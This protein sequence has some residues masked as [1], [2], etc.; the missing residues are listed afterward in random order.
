MRP[1]QLKICGFGPYAGE[2][3]LDLEK[4]G[5]SGLYLIT[6]DT[7]AGKTT[8]FDAICYALFGEASGSSREPG[9]LRSKYAD[10][11]TQTEVELTFENGG[12]QY[13]VKRNPEYL[14][15]KKRG[16]GYTSQP[17]GAEL[18]YPDGRLETKTAAVT[19]AVEE[20][21][22]I[23]RDQ[24]CQ[25]AMIAQGDFLKLLLADTKSRQEIF[26]D[27][28]RTNL[29]QLFQDRVKQ[30]LSE[31]EKTR[32]N[33]KLGVSLAVSGILCREEDPL[34]AK[35]Q[36]A[37]AGEL[38]TEDILTLID[39]LCE[40]DDKTLQRLQSAESEASKKLLTLTETLTKAAQ[41]RKLEEE[42]TSAEEAIRIHQQKESGLNEKL[43]AAEDAAK[44]A[45]A[46]EQKALVL[47]SRLSDYDKL[48]AAA[49]QLES[50]NKTLA[51]MRE[52]LRDKL[53][54]NAQLEETCRALQE[55]LQALAF[56]GENRAVLSAKAQNLTKEIAA[57]DDFSA[58]L[59]AL[60]PL[61]KA[62][63]DAQAAYLAA[64]NAS[65]DAAALAQEYRDR[66][67]REQAGIMA[68][69]LADGKPCPVCGST[70]HPK[71]A[72]KAADAPS[73]AQVKKAE[74]A[75][76]QARKAASDAASKSADAL[77]KRDAAEDAAAKKALQLL[78]GCGLSEAE[79]SLPARIADKQAEWKKTEQD[80][81]R[82]EQRV[83]RRAELEKE[84]PQKE[85][86]RRK[87]AEAIENLKVEG[88]GKK[89]NAEAL[90]TQVEEWKKDLEFSSRSEAE[91]TVAVLQQKAKS[92]RDDLQAAS[93][94]KTE[95]EKDLASLK[96]ARENCEK[97]L[98][99]QAPIDEAAVLEEQRTV[100]TARDQ[101]AERI[102]QTDHCLRANR[103]IEANIR[104]QE[105]LLKDLDARWQWMDALRRTVTGQLQGKERIELETWI[106]MTYFDRILRRA[107]V[108]L[109]EMSSGAYELKRR[110]NA[111][112]LRSQSGLELDVADHYNGSTRSVKTLSGGESFMAS[113][114]LALGLSEE[115]QA[116]AGGVRLDCMFVDE[117]FG[118]LDEDTLQQAMKALG[119]LTEGDRLVGII[120]HVAE[121]RRQI[122]RQIVVTKDPAG[123][124]RAELRL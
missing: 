46:W 33:A 72:V 92:V 96:A 67:N 57:L 85:E 63:T 73:E 97:L 75:A 54:E 119:R 35:V 79:A 40:T 62:V 25:I 23:D 47:A 12:K 38:L 59:K 52:D 30:D 104:S 37:K 22:G 15:K 27:L 117:G 36:Q 51:Q 44:S 81:S 124:S 11:D 86:Q 80:L 70:S 98:S 58:D 21:L 19:R 113:L 41:Q 76:E 99:Q 101:Y 53:Q 107:N 111:D 83:Q 69:L 60:I 10:N 8:I 42:K 120:S 1:L 45:S 122:D 20:I 64:E 118:S 13:T 49:A 43:A 31:L 100:E 65:K 5:T 110:E 87:L 71:K 55:E 106:Q 82:E 116:N 24:F 9:M 18:H 14:R 115:I 50:L 48:D 26:R 123:G 102:R 56:A 7:G 105:S 90:Q 28:F 91:K 2:Q 88:Q 6:G 114:S 39:E 3:V 121:L 103:D 108:H 95:W 34:Y 74:K 94:A 61:R 77:A 17:A 68:E 32:A 109:M 78:D 66:F 84:A 93:S 29:Y 16:D 89:T 112:D 4:L